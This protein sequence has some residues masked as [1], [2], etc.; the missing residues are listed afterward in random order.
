MKDVVYVPLPTVV[1]DT[2]LAALPLDCRIR[3]TSDPHQS[4]L[5]LFPAMRHVRLVLYDEGEQPDES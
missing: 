1:F 4:N 3:D 5:I 2:V